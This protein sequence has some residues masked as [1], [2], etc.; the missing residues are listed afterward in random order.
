MRDPALHRVLVPG[1]VNRRVRAIPV[2]TMS[3]LGLIVGCAACAGDPGTPGPDDP[4][5]QE[6]QPIVFSVSPL[7]LEDLTSIVPLGSLNPP[8]HTIP[9]DHIAFNYVDRCPCD[10]SPRPVFAPA[11]GTVRL[12]LRGDDDGIEIGQPP[13]VA[14]SEYQPWYYMGHV[15]L[16]SDIQVGQRVTAGEQIGTTSPFALGVDLGLVDV[17]EVTNNFI[18][19][20]RYHVKA[21]HGDKPLRHFTSPLRVMLY[22]R[23]LREGPERDGRFDYDAPRRLSGG[24]FHESLPRDNRST[25][26]EGWTRNLA[27]V[28]WERDPTVPVVSVGG[29]ILPALVYWID[30]A[31]PAFGDVGTASGAVRYHLHIARPLPGTTP[32]PDHVLLVQLIADDR[33]KVEVFPGTATPVTFTTNAVEYLR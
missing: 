9:N 23:V 1:L 28:W 16:R 7:R 27:F 29:T 20:L 2:H 31:D 6:R 10:L 8:A 4:P 24:W 30:A 12:I 3:A 26:P 17:Q 11:G 25:G 14:G 32:T 22:S 5:D 18:V 13:D 21:I 15:L 19:P 33:L